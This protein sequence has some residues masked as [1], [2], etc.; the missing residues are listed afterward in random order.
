MFARQRKK[1]IKSIDPN[2]QIIDIIIR[3]ILIVKIAM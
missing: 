3:D 1:K 2:S